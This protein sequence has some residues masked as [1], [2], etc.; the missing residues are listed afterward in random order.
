M[1]QTTFIYAL[2]DPR[3]LDIRYI[4]KA[5]DLQAVER[6]LRGPTGIMWSDKQPVTNSVVTNISVIQDA[7]GTRRFTWPTK[8]R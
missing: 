6:D 7:V 1:S 3:T 2:L 4:G 5:D 8:P